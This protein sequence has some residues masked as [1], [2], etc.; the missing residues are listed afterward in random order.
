MAEREG[1]QGGL[2]R[3]A[4]GV[5]HMV[6]FVVAAAAPLTAVMGVS[7]AAFAFGNGAG[8]PAVFVMVGVLY[9]IFSAGFTAMSRFVGSA[10]GFYPYVAAGLGKP[11]GVATAFIALLAY[12]S[13]QLSLSG[14]FG[15]FVN[16]IVRGAGGPDIAWWIY[17][18]V[19]ALVV[20]LFGRRNI[21]FSGRVLGIC[22]IAEVTILMVLSLDVL[23][24]GGGPDGIVFTS[25][26]PA[27]V[28]TPGLGIALVFVVAAFIGF[29]ATAIFGEEARDPGRTIPIATYTAVTLIA[30]FYSF[31]TW[32][33]VVY[34]GPSHITQEAAQHTATMYDEAVIVLLGAFAGHVMDA[35]LITSIFACALSFHNALN[36]Y[37]YAIGGDGLL[38]R[39]L[40]RTHA[41]HRSPHVAG[42]VQLL[43]V[44]SMLLLLAV[45]GLHPYNVVFAWSG[46]MASL[47][48]L[49]MQALVSLA[50]LGYFAR[51]S[52][53]VS[54]WKRL[55]A[56]LL[57]AAGLITG[58]AMMTDHLSLVSGSQ[59]A[60]VRQFP[61]VVLAV[62]LLGAAM[63]LRLRRSDPLLY[64]SLGQGARL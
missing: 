21:E 27:V 5:T 40:A 53:G 38:W 4:V 54:L 50:V 19:L 18:T 58:L 61:F 59:S 28:F 20:Y 45:A 15:F 42:A 16:S 37:Y 33:I 14:L 6:V 26:D 64:R 9:V 34:Y 22:M 30:L 10:G 55:I 49:T 1:E 35:L 13:V 25:F 57:S 3:D 31:V 11:A 46:T 63:A 44:L 8:V 39:G 51:D 60:V 36:R 29:E 23:V 24:S 56:P 48:V 41:T 2:K 52:R 47:C 62:A 7:P 32:C 43:V 17:A 12:H